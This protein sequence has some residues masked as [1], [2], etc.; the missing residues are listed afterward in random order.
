MN[1]PEAAIIRFST[2]TL[3]Q[4]TILLNST[5]VSVSTAS[6]E[7]P[8]HELVAKVSK[9]GKVSKSL[10]IPCHLQGST[11]AEAEAVSFQ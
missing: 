1:D 3:L 11:E 10:P 7:E 6:T 2:N 9:V 5:T 8:V 4:R